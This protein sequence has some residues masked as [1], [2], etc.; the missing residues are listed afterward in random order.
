MAKIF[1]QSVA[2]WL[3]RT[4]IFKGDDRIQNETSNYIQPVMAIQPNEVVIA[5][6]LYTTTGTV[7]I[8]TLPSTKDC[9][10]TSVFCSFTKD[11]TSDLTSVTVTGTQADDEVNNT[12]LGLQFQTLTAMQDKHQQM[13]RLG[14][15][16]KRGSAISLNKT[17]TAGTT[18]IR[19][20]IFGYFVESISN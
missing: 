12:L 19:V 18:S 3:Q 7:N 13:F 4:F 16:M 9:Y 17:F 8:I 10:I 1:N 15:K 14:I 5:S 2:N 6:G 20:T 11:A